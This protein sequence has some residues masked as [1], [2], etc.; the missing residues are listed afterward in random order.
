MKRM[1]RKFKHGPRIRKL[2]REAQR[3]RRAKLKAQQKGA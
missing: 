2:W 3:R 1:K